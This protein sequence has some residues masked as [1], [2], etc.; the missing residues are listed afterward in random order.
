M[1]PRNARTE[2][3]SEGGFTFVELLV[4][5]SLLLITIIAVMGLSMTSS[6]MT[7][8]ARQRA[9]M[10]N[11]AAGYLER[12]RQEPYA[13][14]GL[15][16]GDPAGDLVSMVTT[17]AP[18]KMTLTPSVTWG[19]P[20]DPTNHSFKTVTVSVAS[21]RV[22]GGSEMT[23]STS[24]VVADVGAVGGS[25]SVVA[26]PTAAIVS[27]ADGSVVWGT[28]S[29]AAS[30]TAGAP[31][32]HL[33]FIDIID[34]LQSWGAVA[35]T[36][37]SAQNTWAWNTTTAREGDHSLKA[38]ATDSA[39]NTGDGTPVK[40][41]VDNAAPS[42]P[43]GLGASFPTGS[44]GLLWW[45]AATDGTAAD[46]VTPLAA[47]HYVVSVYHQPTGTTLA[48]DYT[49]WTPVTGLTSLSV[50]TVPSSG[51]PL[52]MPGL[53][54]F[55]RYCAAVSS[56]SPDRGA[57]SGLLSAPATA[58]GITESTAAG[59]WNASFANKKY[60][61][62]V[63]F[64]VPSGPTFPWTGTATTRYYR[65]TSASQVITSGTLIQT[66]TS[67]YP[68]WSTTAAT[69]TQTTGNNGTP[70]AY[71]YAAVTTLTPTG[72]GSGPTTVSSCVLGPP[73][74]LNGVG[75]RALVVARW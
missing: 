51:S 73:S 44:S 30:A 37:A 70:T 28:A 58:V 46:G 11:A 56:S 54:T 34:G 60:T 68:T 23:Y 36:G 42:V 74:P 24:A 48:S 33:V 22:G 2:V 50:V 40:L 35:V 39:N 12:V 41:T 45:T 64:S 9:A 31:S 26:T 55:S 57:A 5:L 4:A 66:V 25:P 27:P 13:D 69:D 75:T 47:S 8:A 20:E 61:V 15:P 71:Y 3:P 43:G 38:R 53:A 63:S 49:K 59:T 19:R 1:F 10:V 32:I 52:N 72:F 17:S 67:T 6:F 7:N 16:G 21:S 62:N 14:V 65:L 18:Y 29:V